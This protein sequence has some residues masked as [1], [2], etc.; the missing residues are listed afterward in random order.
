[1][2]LPTNTPTEFKV[3]RVEEK[4]TLPAKDGRPA[5]MILKLGVEANGSKGW[6][7]LFA[8]I[9]PATWPVEGSTAT[10]IAEPPREEGWNYTLKRP[11]K[12]GA[13]RGRSPQETKAIQRQ[14]A[15][16]DAMEY[17]AINASCNGKV[18]S[19]DQIKAWTDELEAWV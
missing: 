13:P 8:D 16:R 2:T 18:P 4:K 17:A 1:M 3:H 14:S 5:K 10:F 11:S 9:D 15:R 12:G 6:G 7:D 19:L